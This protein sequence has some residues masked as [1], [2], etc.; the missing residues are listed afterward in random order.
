MVQ[1]LQ[2]S[3][4]GGTKIFIGGHMETKLGAE[5]GGKAIQGLP[6]LRI[7]PTYIQPP[8]LDN[9]D[10]AKKCMLT[11]AGYRCLLRGSAST[12]QIQRGMLGANH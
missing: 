12:C 7:Q 4:K 2:S 11:G 6:H 5:M 8:K 3:L 9:I 10:E 1:T